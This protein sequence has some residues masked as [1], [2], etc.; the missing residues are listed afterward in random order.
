M[1][2]WSDLPPVILT[3]LED[4][5]M[6]NPREVTPDV[7]V[8]W[9]RWALEAMSRVRAAQGVER[10]RFLEPEPRAERVRLATRYLRGDGI[11]IGALHNPLEVPPDA[12]VRYTDLWDVDHLRLIHFEISQYRLV[13]VDVQDDGERLE[14][15]EDESLDFVISNHFL[16]HCEN[17][18]EALRNGVRVLRPGGILYLAV[19]DARTTFD[20]TRER[21]PFE[22]LWRDYTDGPA[23]SRQEHYR[24]FS[25]KVNQR[26]GTE[27]EAWWRLLDAL[28]HAIHFHV[29]TPH[30]V[31]ELLVE[32]TN[33]LE[34]SVELREFVVHANESVSILQRS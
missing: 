19:P 15:F 4:Y 34:L 24:D 10:T 31:L 5:R 13:P 23:W 16:E 8:W 6:A 30:D 7:L 20:R 17:P 11:E 26:S 9:E 21:T 33:R 22:H 25:M 12:N 32:A 28:N 1:Q 27:H 3:R 29:W 2:I 14:A 18:L